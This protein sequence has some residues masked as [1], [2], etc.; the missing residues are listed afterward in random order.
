MIVGCQNWGPTQRLNAALDAFQS[1]NPSGAWVPV[2]VD[3]DGVIDFHAPDMDKDGRADRDTTGAIIEVPG[4]RQP[5]DAAGQM[6]TEAADILTILAGITGVSIIGAIGSY[7]GRRKP[8]KRLTE[9][10]AKFTT[11][12][13]GIEKA[14]EAGSPEGVITISAAALK[15]ALKAIP[16]LRAE[17]DKVRNEIQ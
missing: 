2:D 15:E 11:L 4:T 14:K 6:D 16:E 9:A 5:L 7:I 12:V 17:I 10:G 1:A 13:Q 8:I 3:G